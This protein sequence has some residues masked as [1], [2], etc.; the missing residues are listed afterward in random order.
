VVTPVLGLLVDAV[1]A[2]TNDER[3]SLHDKIVKTRVVRTK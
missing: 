2:L 3:K 1:V